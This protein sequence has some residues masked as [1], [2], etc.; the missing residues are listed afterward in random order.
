MLRVQQICSWAAF[1]IIT[2]DQDAPRCSS[3]VEKMNMLWFPHTVEYPTPCRCIIYHDVQHCGRISKVM[4]KEAR[5]RREHRVWFHLHEWQ[6]RAKL[7]GAIRSWEGTSS[8]GGD[9]GWKGTLGDFGRMGKLYFSIW[10]LVAWICS[11]CENV[12]HFF[13]FYA[14]HFWRVLFPHLWQPLVAPA[15]PGLW[16]H[17]SL[18]VCIWPSALPMC[19]SPKD[20]C[21]CI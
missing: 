4:H 3:T 16:P 15:F 2:S 18:L 17:H 7:L 5:L 14:E 10:V 11:V 20:T 19:V 6:E 12:E 8:W 21:H 9:G 13:F 1:V